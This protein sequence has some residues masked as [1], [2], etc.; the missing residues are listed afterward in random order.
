LTIEQWQ[1][2]VVGVDWQQLGALPNVNWQV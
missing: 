2:L 1:G